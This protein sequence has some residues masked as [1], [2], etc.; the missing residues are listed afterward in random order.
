VYEKNII[1]TWMLAFCWS[2][3]SH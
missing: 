1:Y 2:P 3:I